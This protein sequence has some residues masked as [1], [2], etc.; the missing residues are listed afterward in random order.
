MLLVT[1]SDSELTLEQLNFFPIVLFVAVITF[2]ATENFFLQFFIDVELVFKFSDQ[3]SVEIE[4]N[5][6]LDQPLVRITFLLHVNYSE[7]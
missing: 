5:V 7:S 3:F 6:V 4:P 2:Y 1:V